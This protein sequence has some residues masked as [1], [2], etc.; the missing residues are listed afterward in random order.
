MMKKRILQRQGGYRDEPE[1]AYLLFAH[2][3]TGCN[4][5]SATH[6]FG[7]TSAFKNSGIPL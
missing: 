4:M 1:T 3:V 5:T 2:A 7:K 6:N